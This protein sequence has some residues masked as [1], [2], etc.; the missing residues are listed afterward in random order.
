MSHN[1]PNLE[2]LIA[3][4]HE[5]AALIKAGVPL[6]FG[7]RGLSGLKGSRLEQLSHRLA[8]RLA[9]GRTLPDA[10]AE[11][12]S[13]ISP[14]YVAVVEAGLA[15]GKLPEALESLA[16]SGQI[17]LDTRR[18]V[19]LAAIYPTICVIVG[20]AMFCLFISG[21]APHV[22]SAVEMLPKSWPIAL[23]QFLHQKQNY[24]LVVIP[25]IVLVLAV[26]TFVFRSGP[27]RRLWLWMTSVRWIIGRN[28]NWAQF[29]ELLA[30]QVD[31]SCP[32][33][34]AFVLAADSTDDARWRR[35]A[36]SVSEQLSSGSS[37][38][39]A[40]HSATS[41][42][43]M[44]RWMIAS[45]EKQGTLA[46][47]LRQLSDIYRRRALRRMAVLRVWL[48]VAMTICFTGTIGL[49]YGLAFVL[50]LRAFLEGM[51]VE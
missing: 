14:I 40:L 15:S 33:P 31:Q 34:K 45:G 38:E 44:V 1:P 7:L 12:G 13:V 50:P 8:D 27:T 28:L 39:T 51:M 30:L 2:D 17:Q 19:F 6:E 4:N 21:P 41:L 36:H 5:I 32:L 49:T 47:A 22:I 37:L 48:P 18:Q 24:F 20:Y 42:P 10:L 16:N 29:T 46:L 3:L 9:N 23:L 11:E 43:P 25:S 35:E 26:L